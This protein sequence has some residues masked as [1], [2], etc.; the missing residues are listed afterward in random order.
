[1]RTTKDTC[2]CGSAGFLDRMRRSVTRLPAPY[3]GH[4]IAVAG[5]A[6]A[7]FLLHGLR[8]PLDNTYVG[9]VFLMVVTVVSVLGGREPAVLAAV[10]AFLAWDF[11]FLPPLYTFA[12]DSPQDW[13]MLLAF[14]VIGV[15]VGHMTGRLRLREEEAVRRERHTA[16]LYQA[17]REA[18]AQREVK[19]ALTVVLERLLA[20]TPADAVALVVTSPAAPEGCARMAMGSVSREEV[21]QLS[22]VAPRVLAEGKAV[23]L[24]TP[25]PTLDTGDLDWP[26]SV[27]HAAVGLEVH[28]DVYLPLVVG[29]H[30]HGLLYARAGAG[31]PFEAH[32]LRL[33]VG[34]ASQAASLLERHR[35]HEAAGRAFARQE[36]E[37]L[38]STLLSSLSHNLKTPLV[39]LATTLSSL[40]GGDVEWERDVLE[41]SLDDMAE[42]VRR[43]REHI[44]NLLSIAHLECGG[45]EPRPELVDLA[46][47]LQ[48]SQRHLRESDRRRIHVERLE[49][50]PALVVDATQMAQV[51]GHL[52]E[53]ALAYS[54]SESP[55][56]VDARLVEQHLE[57]RVQDHG[58]GIAPEERELIFQKFFRGTAA[59]RGAVRG[60]GLGLAISREIVEAHG[61]TLALASSPGPGACFCISLP[62]SEPGGEVTP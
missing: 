53:N 11:F 59:R 31:A 28:D 43:L 1:M 9:L 44:D 8:T 47:L 14:L 56:Q 54:P 18:V 55:V 2:C 3:R 26:V 24:H 51:L 39:S 17:T 40:R 58:P 48:A 15:V 29:E 32:D 13:L 25:P 38:K 23:G 57:I 7:T 36:A 12:V 10:L 21:E 4:L 37:R 27:P 61:G 5:I 42:D 62:L 41:E 60:T 20:S 49:G 33:L 6:L 45:W 19:G 35:L 52:L 30:V 50:L 16:A 22:Q 46:D 34:M